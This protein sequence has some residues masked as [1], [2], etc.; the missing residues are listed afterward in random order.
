MK[1]FVYLY[2]AAHLAAKDFILQSETNA[3]EKNHA[4]SGNAQIALRVRK[5]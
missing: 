5:S 4:V 2:L 3:V 1:V